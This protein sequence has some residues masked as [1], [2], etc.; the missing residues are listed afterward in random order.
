M[1]WRRRAV[2]DLEAEWVIDRFAWLVTTLGPRTFFRHTRLVL[3]TQRY[4]PDGLGGA[5]VRPGPLF[6]EIRAYL[7][8]NHWP[9]KLVELPD[10]P[11]LSQPIAGTFYED[12]EGPAIVSYNPG[13]LK[14]P[15]AFIGTM[16]HEL[17]HYIL[18][19]HVE[20]A[21]GGE[22]EHEELT[23]LAVIYAGF[24]LIDLLASRDQSRHGY[25]TTS[26]RAYALA[27]FLR[28]K[29]VDAAVCGPYMSGGLQRAL[30]RALAQ[31]DDRADELVIL[32]G[33]D[34]R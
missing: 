25:L 17:S 23:D 21:P 34:G 2:S 24:G 10:G 4:F 5:G 28:L 9:V 12:E 22:S 19:P 7:G 13:L 1:I 11:G 29:A 18:A 15:N 33:M 3:P 6:D 30:A 32:K 26:V 14:R 27:T 16:A 31:R 8:V 20:S